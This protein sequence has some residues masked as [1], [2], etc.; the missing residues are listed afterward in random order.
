MVLLT[1]GSSRQECPRHI[2][3]RS[4][5]GEVR[6]GSGLADVDA[7]GA[8]RADVGE[9]YLEGFVG[10]GDLIGFHRRARDVLLLIVGRARSDILVDHQRPVIARGNGIDSVGADGNYGA[11]EGKRGLGEQSHRSTAWTPGFAVDDLFFGSH[12]VVPDINLTSVFKIA[13]GGTWRIAGLREQ[14]RIPQYRYENSSPDNRGGHGWKAS[15][16]KCSAGRG[17]RGSVLVA[18]LDM[19]A[20]GVP[21]G[22]GLR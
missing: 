3:L 17:W 13:G 19:W 15:A 18:G 9:S 6:E 2:T 12:R 10:L 20:E 16:E 8:T 11:A 7:Q 4:L 1:A 5:R 14:P 22:A 21:I